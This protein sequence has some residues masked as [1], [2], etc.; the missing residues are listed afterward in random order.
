M[1]SWN[2]KLLRVSKTEILD[3]LTKLKP[4]ERQ[5]IRAK[6]NELDGIAEE[7]WSDDGELTDEEKRILDK[8]LAQFEADPN[9]G[10]SWQESEARIREKLEE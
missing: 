9:S 10:S 1:K 6:L 2:G 7:A 8:R 4:E 5:E 3:E